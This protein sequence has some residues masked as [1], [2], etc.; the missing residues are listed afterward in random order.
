M[1][2]FWGDLYD[3]VHVIV[4]DVE[5][6]PF[7]L[8]LIIFEI[9]C[10]KLFYSDPIFRLVHEL[11]NIFLEVYCFDIDEL[12]SCQEHDMVFEFTRLPKDEAAAIV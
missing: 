1:W 3:Y 10:F 8:V 11:L 9:T 4:D 12:I 6:F 7:A 2:F 5:I